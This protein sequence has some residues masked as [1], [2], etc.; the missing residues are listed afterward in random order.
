MRHQ[1][2]IPTV[3]LFDLADKL[4]QYK[5]YTGI[6]GVPSSRKHYFG[7]QFPTNVYLPSRFGLFEGRQVP[8]ENNIEL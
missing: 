4:N 8:I 5:S 1:G 6:S 3:D 7:E 2:F